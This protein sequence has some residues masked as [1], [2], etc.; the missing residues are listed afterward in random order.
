LHVSQGQWPHDTLQENQTKPTGAD[1]VRGKIDDEDG[2]LKMTP[3]G[4]V[5]TA[6]SS[7][8]WPRS[9]AVPTNTKATGTPSSWTR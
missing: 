4:E 1:R 2:D 5:A 6:A 7:K 9:S 8:P 3:E